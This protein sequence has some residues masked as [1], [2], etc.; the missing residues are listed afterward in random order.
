MNIKE[1]I[2]EM[3]LEEKIGQLNQSA[4]I[5][6]KIDEIEDRIRSGR[7]GSIILAQ[8]AFAG[9]DKSCTTKYERLNRLQR[10]AVEETNLHIPILFG[11]DVIHGHKTVF[12]IPLAMAASFNMELI[13]KSYE[14][15]AKEAYNDGIKWTFAPMLDLSRDPRWGRIIESAGEDPYLA[16]N[17]AKAVIGGFQGDDYSVAGKLCACA[18]HFV[19]YGASEGGRD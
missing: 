6:E 10:I 8:S 5:P 16:Q 13:K 14:C 4:Y 12:P 2:K 9:N 7:V 1:L 18:K 11:K 17:V 15:I 19:G 3:T